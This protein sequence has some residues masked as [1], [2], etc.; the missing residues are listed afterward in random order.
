MKLASN[1]VRAIKIRMVFYYSDKDV[2]RH[3]ATLRSR[4]E[5]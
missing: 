2:V 3:E 1:D 5:R 4:S